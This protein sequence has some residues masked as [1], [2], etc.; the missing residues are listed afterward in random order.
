M[1]GENVFQRYLSKKYKIDNLTVQGA[2]PVIT[3]SREMGCFAG[4]IAVKL[5]N[6]INQYIETNDSK[7]KWCWISKEI[8]EKSAEELKIKPERISHIFDAKK[9][10]LFEDLAD[11]F[12]KKYYVS[13]SQIIATIQNIIRTSAYEGRAVIVGRASAVIT[14][15]I[16]RAL[17]IK[18]IAPVDFRV[19]LLCNKLKVTKK[20]AKNSLVETDRKRDAFIKFF[21]G[22]K[23][24]NDY[25]DVILNRARFDEDK[26]VDIIFDLAKL[27]KLI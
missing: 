13:D 25:Y 9:K 10:A 1:S 2:G 22:T 6:K 23:P 15:E 7:K 19:K 21:R 4:D 18:L 16:Q 12:I 14:N 11:S 5:V 8:L 20:E 17:H 3:I 24:E 26:I 27:R